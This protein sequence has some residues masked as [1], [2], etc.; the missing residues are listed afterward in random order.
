MSENLK[1]FLETV[2]KDKALAEKLNG[3]TEET[4]IVSMAAELGLE[5]TEED[6]G[7]PEGE[8]DAAELEGVVGGG[9]CYCVAGGG[10][11]KGERSDVCACVLFGTGFGNAGERCFCSGYGHG[12]AEKKN[13]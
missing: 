10:G 3:L 2:S 6:F 13:D 11:T 9:E 4:Q 1:T 5:L 7:L 12:D 8:L